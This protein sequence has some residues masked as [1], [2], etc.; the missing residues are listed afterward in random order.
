MRWLNLCRPKSDQRWRGVG[1]ASFSIPSLAVNE[2]VVSGSRGAGWQ[3]STS[4]IS[5]E[6]LVLVWIC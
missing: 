6:T 5:I 2:L 4:I 3:P 1:I